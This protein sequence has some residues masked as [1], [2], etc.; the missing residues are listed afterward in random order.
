MLNFKSAVGDNFTRGYG[1]LENFLSRQRSKIANRIIPNELREGKILDIGCGSIPF[2]LKSVLF[3]E[4]YG[5]DKISC[6]NTPNIQF[7]RHDFEKLSLL[8]FMDNFFD[9][10]SLL[11]VIEHFQPEKVLPLIGEIRRVLKPNGILILTTPAAWS[12]GLLRFMA[13]LRLASSVE[14]EEH[15]DIYTAKKLKNILNQSGFLQSEIQAGYFECFAN[16]WVK[17]KK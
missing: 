2:F 17:A 1:F 4:K 5:I 9:V 11:A 3:K 8:P 10:V 14:I 6:R 16:I 13:K 15:K 7:I 12:D